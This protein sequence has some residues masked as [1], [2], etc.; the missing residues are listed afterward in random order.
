MVTS[1]IIGIALCSYDEKRFQCR[2]GVFMTHV[3]ATNEQFQTSML[4]AGSQKM[5]TYSLAVC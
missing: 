1:A 3:V 4:R 2:K 5:H